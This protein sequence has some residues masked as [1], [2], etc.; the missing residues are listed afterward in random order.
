MNKERTGTISGGFWLR[1]MTKAQFGTCMGTGG[2]QPRDSSDMMRT[3]ECSLIA[4]SLKNG[5]GFPAR[6]PLS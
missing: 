4:R 6:M 1:V 5:L 3:T 2:F